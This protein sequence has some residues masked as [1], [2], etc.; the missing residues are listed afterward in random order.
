M[1]GLRYVHKPVVVQAMQVPPVWD[2]KNMPT[3]LV[4]LANWLGVT[5]QW[6]IR[7]DGSVEIENYVET[8]KVQPGDWI[9]RDATGFFHF[10][11]DATFAERYEALV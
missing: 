8:V 11:D 4:A 2:G 10:C 5:G 7:G 3:A 6:A 1:T 9:I